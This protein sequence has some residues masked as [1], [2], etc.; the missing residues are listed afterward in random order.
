MKSRTLRRISSTSGGNEKSIMRRSLARRAVSAGGVRLASRAMPIA[1]PLVGPRHASPQGEEKVQAVREMFDAIAPRYDLVN[2]MMTFRLDVRWRRRAV[3]A[4]ALPARLDWCSIWPR[5]RATC[6]S[7]CAAPGIG[8]SRSTSRSGCSPPTARGAPRVQADILRLPVPDGSVDGVTCGFA[9]RNLVELGAFFDELGR[10]RAPRRP[11]RAARRRHPA[12]PVHPLGQ[13]H[14]LRQG[15]APDRRAAVRRRRVPVPAQERGLPADARRDGV[16]A[17]AT[18]GFTTGRA[19]RPVGGL[20]Q[21]LTATRAMIAQ[22]APP[23]DCDVDLND[24]AAWRRVPVRARRR[25]LRRP[26]RRGTGADRRGGRVPRRDRARRRRS[27]DRT[28]RSRSARCRSCPDA[29][30][31]SSSRRRRRQGCRRRARGSR[32]STAPTSRSAPPTPDRPAR[33]ASYTLRP[34]VD[35]DHYLAAVAA[36]RDAVRAGRIDKAV[37]ARPIAVES[38]QPDRRPR[39]AAAAQ[40]H[41]RLE[42]PLLGRRLRRRLA[43]AA[44]RG[45]RRRRAVASRSPAR[46]RTTGDPD[47][48]AELAA[49]L[50]R[51][52]RTRSSTGPRSRWCATRCCPSAATSTGRPSR[53]SSRSPT[54]STSARRPRVGCR[55]RHRP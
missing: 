55:S 8:R 34:L 5:A 28:G 24:V 4:L 17:P 19:S 45:R 29:P 41:V 38:D 47:L 50:M 21:L 36:A 51:A 10:G 9:L 11:D 30:A 40:G 37:I 7:T 32:R 48:D 18:P 53:R 44:G 6:A 12:Q 54:C 23:L 46:R 2:R 13:R 26:R 1:E 35:V 27:A 33:A 16:D 42:P 31:S 49:E 43:R 20:T 14:L 22:H 3:R 25:R 39:R 52:R 15:R